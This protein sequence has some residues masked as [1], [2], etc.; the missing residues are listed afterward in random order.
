MSPAAIWVPAEAH[1]DRRVAVDDRRGRLEPQRLLDG[2]TDQRQVGKDEVELLVVREEVPDEVED[3]PLGRLDPT[4]QHHSGVRD[5]LVRAQRPRV[6]R[7]GQY[8]RSSAVVNVS[9]QGVTQRGE[10]SAPVLGRRTAERC[11]RHRVDDRRVPTRKRGYR[12]RVGSVE[13]DGFGDNR[14]RERIGERRAQLGPRRD[15][16]GVEQTL[17]FCG[18]EAAEA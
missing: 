16:D 17:G 4:E 9:E 13:A 14:G 12:R 7:I 15:D 5:H 11:S 8:G 3:H 6:D 1:V 10:R 2:V 18:H